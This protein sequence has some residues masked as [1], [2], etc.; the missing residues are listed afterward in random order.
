[1]YQRQSTAGVNSSPSKISRAQGWTNCQIFALA[2]KQLS[3]LLLSTRDFLS[4]FSSARHRSLASY[5]RRARVKDRSNDA[6]DEPVLEHVDA[7]G[8]L[9]GRRRRRRRAAALC[10]DRNARGRLYSGGTIRGKL[11]SNKIEYIAMGTLCIHTALWQD[12]D[13]MCCAMLKSAAI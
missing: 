4:F 10:E 5:R 1:M 8:C 9:L 13:A 2:R 3:Y 6:A 11:V 7:D 12:H